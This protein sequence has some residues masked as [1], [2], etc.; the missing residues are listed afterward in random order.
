MLVPTAVARRA[1]ISLTSDNPGGNSYGVRW[2]CLFIPLLFVFLADAYAHLAEPRRL[3][4][5]SG[6]PSPRRSPFA[7]I[8]SPRSVARPDP[9]GTGYSWQIV[10]RAHGWL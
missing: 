10:L 3:A 6:S 7:L 1:T 9:Y 2:F 8:G 4:P 5:P